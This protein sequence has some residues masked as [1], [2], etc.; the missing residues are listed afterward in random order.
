M[1][2]TRKICALAAGLVLG[3]ISFQSASACT[4]GVCGFQGQYCFCCEQCGSETC[5]IL[6]PDNSC[7][8]HNLIREDD[9][10]ISLRSQETRAPK[11]A[12]LG[13]APEKSWLA[14][15]R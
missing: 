12:L 14:Q 3:S 11:V 10:F 5:D 15:L 9:A 13:A 8:S 2:R 7:S 4:L 6:K 1:S